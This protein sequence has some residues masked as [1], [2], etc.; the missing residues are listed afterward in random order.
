MRAPG[1]RPH[2]GCP[3]CLQ[4][5][6]SRQLPSPSSALALSSWA[7]SV[8][9]CPSGRR[10]TTCCGPRPCSTLLQVDWGLRPSTGLGG[11]CRGGFSAPLS[12]PPW[13]LGGGHFPGSI[14]IQG[15]TWPGPQRPQVGWRETEL[16]GLSIPPHDSTL[17]A[18]KKLPRE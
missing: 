1:L 3:L 13:D 12:C 9:S 15:Q 2:A 6:A 4:S 10:G 8:S 14:P 18:P 5:T 11:P 17:K 7:A 16:G